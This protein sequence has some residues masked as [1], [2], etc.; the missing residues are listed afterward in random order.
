[1]VT[2]RL[3]VRRSRAGGSPRSSLPDRKG[4]ARTPPGPPTVPTPVEAGADPRSPTR[5]PY[6]DPV[7]P[8]ADPPGPHARRPPGPADPAAR[9]T[10]GGGRG[11]AGH[12][13]A[14]AGVVG[15][16]AAPARGR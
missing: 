12:A 11:L 2:I 13:T 3:P 7:G 16:A 10:A 4:G 14:A 15:R 1:M 9:G 5:T 6:H 8:A